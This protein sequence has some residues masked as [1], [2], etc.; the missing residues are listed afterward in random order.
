MAIHKID[1]VDAVDG[2]STGIN[3]FPKKFVTLYCTAAVTAG[4]WVSIHAT[5]DENGLGASVVL[6]PV[7]PSSTASNAATFGIATE[8]TTAA[9]NLRVQTAGKYENAYVDGSTTV[10][11]PLTGPLSGGTA[12]MAS[13]LAETTYGPVIGVALESDA[14]NLADVMIIDQGFF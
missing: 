14:T 11:L 6:A 3:S 2:S 5:D 13:L 4:R 10:G 8:T 12:G 7:G 9:G 1:G